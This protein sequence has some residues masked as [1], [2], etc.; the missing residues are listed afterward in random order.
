MRER[1]RKRLSYKLSDKNK[2]YNIAL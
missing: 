2:I 1:E